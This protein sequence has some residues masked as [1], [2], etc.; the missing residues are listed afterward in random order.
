MLLD[1]G[2]ARA[3]EDRRRD[4]HAL[5]Q[6]LASSISCSSSSDR[7]RGRRSPRRRSRASL[8]RSSPLAPPWRYPR[9]SRRSAAEAGAGPA[10]MRLEDLPDIHARRHAERVQHESTGVPSSRYGMSSIGTIGDHALVAVAAGHLVARLQLALHRDEDLDHLH[11]AGR[12][13]VAALQLL[14]LVSKRFCRRSTAASN[15]ASAPR[16][17]PSPLV[18]LDGD[19]PPLAARTRRAPRR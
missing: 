13:L 9:P 11:H 18:V 1:V 2:L 16:S 15:C 12:Q 5:L 19:L 3:V 8:A 10:E 14:D 17:R 7:C 4:R 6:V